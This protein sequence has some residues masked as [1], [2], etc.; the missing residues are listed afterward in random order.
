LKPHEQHRDVAHEKVG[1]LVV[2]VSTSRYADSQAAR[3]FTDE[4]GDAAEKIIRKHGHKVRGRELISDDV[5][6][7]RGALDRGLQTK[8][9]G[10]VLFTGGTGVSPTDVTI[11][12]V[13][14]QLDK[15]IVGFG[16]LFRAVGYEKIG[17]PAVLSRATAGIAR[18]KLVLCLP[19]S[20]DGVKTALKLFMEDIPHLVHVAAGK[21]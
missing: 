15:E 9:V 18:G 7:I 1:F 2:T 10:A 8:S 4:S 12:A 20:P 21:H 3:K 14:P 13:R 19:G 11:E 6:Q 5:V 17:F 16:E